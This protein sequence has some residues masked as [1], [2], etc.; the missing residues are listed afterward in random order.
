MYEAITSL[1][2]RSGAN[3]NYQAELRVRLIQAEGVEWRAGL[4]PVCDGDDALTPITL[5]HHW[6][7]LAVAY[8]ETAADALDALELECARDVPA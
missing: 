1:I 8:G 6:D 3:S 7:L 2:K 5:E 4:Y